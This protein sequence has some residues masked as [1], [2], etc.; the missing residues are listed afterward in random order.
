MSFVTIRSGAEAV[1]PPALADRFQLQLDDGDGWC[2]GRVPPP[3]A[4]KDEGPRVN[5]APSGPRSRTPVSSSIE[6]TL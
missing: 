3:T 2:V 1:L 6:S 5:W 4:Q